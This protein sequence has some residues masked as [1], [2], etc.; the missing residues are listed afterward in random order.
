MEANQPYRPPQADLSSSSQGDG[1]ITPRMIE[2][3]RKTRP[4]VLFLAVLG[5]IVTVLVVVLG[6]GFGV[7]MLASGENQ[8]MAVLGVIYLFMALI[9]FFPCYYL[10]KYAAAIKS[11]VGGGGTAAMEEALARQYSFWRLIGILTLVLFGLYA[12]ILV[13]A[14]VMGL[15]AA[16]SA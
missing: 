5:L 9:Y 3:L 11:L 15:I 1:G 10:L 7:V 6:F 16:G 8:E 4:W 12:L 2:L 14:V 13:G